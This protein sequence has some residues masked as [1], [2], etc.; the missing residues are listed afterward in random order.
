MTEANSAKAKSRCQGDVTLECRDLLRG[1]RNPGGLGRNSLANEV[2]RLAGKGS[3]QSFVLGDVISRA[4]DRLEP[5]DGALAQRCD[6]DREPFASVARDLGISERHLYRK[7]KHILQQLAQ[8]VVECSRD[9]PRIYVDAASS[10]RGQLQTSRVLEENGNFVIAAD[11]IERMIAESSQAQKHGLILSLAELYARSGCFARAEQRVQVAAAI[12]RELPFGNGTLAA[13]LLVTRAYVFEECGQGEVAVVKSAAAATKLLYTANTYRYDVDAARV[14]LKALLLWGQ[15]Y[16]SCGQ[17]SELAQICEQASEVFATIQRPTEE[18]EM[19]MLF[20][21]SLRDVA[22]AGDTISACV[23][24]SQAAAVAKRAG[25]TRSAIMHMTNLASV[26]RLRKEPLRAVAILADLLPVA[27]GLGNTTLLLA[28]FVELAAEYV[29]LGE[30]EHAQSLLIEAATLDSSNESLRASMLR[31]SAR[32]NLATKQFAHALDDARLSED[33][34]AAIGKQRLVGVPLR[35]EA[36]AL[37]GLGERRAALRAA[38]SAISAL[39]STMGSQA[40]L[41]DAYRVLGRV[42]GNPKHLHAAKSLS[43]KRKGANLP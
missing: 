38:E 18:I 39:A 13:E 4:L 29:D 27:R 31:T 3:D 1:F 35:L 37:L 42:T 28:L 17:G 7:R 8:F 32:V 6:I 34:F 33:R 16:F 14:L 40:A 15:S 30:Y 41:S 25:L 9:L 24:L 5:K 26:Y 10:R 21:G 36:E 43:G 12:A 23:R 22:C 20:L 11:I 2:F 19:G